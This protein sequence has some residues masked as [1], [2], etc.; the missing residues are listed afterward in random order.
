MFRLLKLCAYA[1][2]G[3]ALYEFFRGMNDA[4]SSGGRR[5]MGMRGTGRAF[6]EQPGEGQITGPGGAGRSEATLDNDGGSV[7]H[8]VGRGVVSGM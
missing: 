2:F 7:P 3:Y 6:N 5:S 8:R 4:G 1:L